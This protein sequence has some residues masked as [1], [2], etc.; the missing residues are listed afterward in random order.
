MYT[1]VAV[2]TRSVEAAFVAA[3]SDRRNGGIA[4]PGD[5]SCTG[6]M[7]APLQSENEISC[8]QEIGGGNCKIFSCR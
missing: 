2:N 4:I 3:V 7:P 8:R 5:V 1:R 6:K